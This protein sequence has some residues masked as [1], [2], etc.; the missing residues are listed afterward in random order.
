[1]ISASEATPEPSATYSQP[2]T[3]LPLGRLVVT[4]TVV[5]GVCA[6]E[7][8]WKVGARSMGRA[9][10]AGA[11]MPR[12]SVATMAAAVRRLASERVMRLSPCGPGPDCSNDPVDVVVVAIMGQR[13][14]LR[15]GPAGVN[16]M[17]TG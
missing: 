17:P 10:A 1:M 2:D 3:L 14:D 6:R 7:V 9:P 15:H 11:A 4:W 16:A 5:A 8:G 12:A 13:W